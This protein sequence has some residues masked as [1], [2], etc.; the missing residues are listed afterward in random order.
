MLKYYRDG[1]AIYESSGTD[2]KDDARA[3]LRVREGDIVKVRPSCRG[4]AEC[5]SR[6]PCRMW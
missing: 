2:I 3:L 6:M 4:R 5:D 1:R